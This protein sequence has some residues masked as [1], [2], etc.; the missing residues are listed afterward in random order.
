M[1]CKYG[2]SICEEKGSQ[3]W[4]RVRFDFLLLVKSHGDDWSF[5]PLPPV[6]LGLHRG[7]GEDWC[8]HLRVMG[9]SPL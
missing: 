2:T 9:A 6:G 8:S 4:G 5:L 3:E 1:E 7:T